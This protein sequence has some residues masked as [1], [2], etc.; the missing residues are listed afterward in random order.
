V[1]SEIAAVRLSEKKDKTRS[2]NQYPTD[3]EEDFRLI[4]AGT[5]SLL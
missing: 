3:A 4:K 5:N 2:P 1:E